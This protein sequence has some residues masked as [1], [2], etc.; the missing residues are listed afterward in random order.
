MIWPWHAGRRF[1]PDCG[2]PVEII[3][4][5]EWDEEAKRFVGAKVMK[6]GENHNGDIVI[7]KPDGGRSPILQVVGEGET[8]HFFESDNM[9]FVPQITLKV[10]EVTCMAWQ[11]LREGA[12]NAGCA[13]HIKAM[14]DAERVSILSSLQADRLKRKCDELWTIHEKHEKNWNETAYIMLARSLGTTSNKEAFGELAQRVKYA[15][16]SRERNDI[17]VVEAML[18]G[19]SGLLEIYGDDRYTRRLRSHFEHL[20]NKYSLTAMQPGAWKI[21]EN[22]KGGQPSAR[23]IQLAAF[24]AE[25]EYLF[26]NTIACRT[27]ED[28]HRLFRSKQGQN[29]RIG[30]FITNTLGIN[31]VVTMQFSYGKYLG[32]EKM[33][34]AALTLLEKTGYES[35]NLV[36][37]WLKGGVK[38]ES[39]FDSQ[40][41]IQ[42]NN[43]YC[44]KGRCADCIIGR[45]V[46]RRVFV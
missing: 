23:I 7:G 15:W 33:C 3:A 6:G 14:T 45:R 11:M 10:D 9:S 34:E 36:N 38:L 35:N 30:A 41:I 8:Q 22:Y 5:G 13:G 4:A 18:L 12:N 31:F 2:G 43:E 25:G 21:N 46:I 32:D 19:T 24:L 40:A 27:V 29:K 1:D 39:A 37:A 28:V 17:E 26:D 42:L 44:I 20:R 16:I